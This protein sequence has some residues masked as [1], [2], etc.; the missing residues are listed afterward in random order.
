MDNRY[1]SE[2]E[3]EEDNN[4]EIPPVNISRFTWP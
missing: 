1:V 4:L 2:A 3:A